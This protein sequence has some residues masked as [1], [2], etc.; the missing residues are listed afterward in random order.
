MT[1]IYNWVE[2]IDENELEKCIESIKNGK[3]VI[4]PTETVYGIGTNAFCEESVE[5]IYEIKQRPRE[6]ALSILVANKKDISKYAIISSEIER[7]IIEN[8]MPGPITIILKQKPGVL[9]Y[10]SCDKD[11]IGIRIPDNK[12]INKILKKAKI[13]V[14]APSANISGKPSGI[15]LSQIIGDFKD[16]V[17]I[18]IDGGKCEDTKSSTIVQIINEKPVIIREGKITLNQINEIIK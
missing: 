2:Q 5:K 12:I 3:I 11:T 18:C 13:P 16:K 4:F 17:D 14:V 9:D 8:F 10:V 1:E 7:K 6:K 15:E